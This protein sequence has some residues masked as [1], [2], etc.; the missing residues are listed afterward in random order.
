MLYLLVYILI[1]YRVESAHALLKRYI[2][3]SQGDLLTTWCSIEQ[4]VAN[5]I[6]NIKTNSAKDRIRTPLDID[7][8]QFQ[9]CFSQI[10]VTAIRLAYN[11]YI[12]TEKPLKPCTGVYTTTTGLPCAHILEDKRQIRPF[13][14]GFP[15]TLALGSVSNLNSTSYS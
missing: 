9:A 7:R 11:N 1:L 13:T 2:Q 3:S 12:R 4:A 15:Y 6:L 14:P 10:T 5:Q 8:T